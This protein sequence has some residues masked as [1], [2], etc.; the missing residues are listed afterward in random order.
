MEAVA[1]D[2][3]SMSAQEVVAPRR[4]IATKDVDLKIRIPECGGQVW[5]RSNTR[6]S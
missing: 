4:A 6:G 1:S 3:L 2:T 5:R